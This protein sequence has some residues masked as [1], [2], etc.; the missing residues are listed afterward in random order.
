M[1]TDIGMCSTMRTWLQASIVRGSKFHQERENG[2]F[3]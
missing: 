1:T 3:N 2:Y